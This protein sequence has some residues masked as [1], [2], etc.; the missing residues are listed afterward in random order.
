MKYRDGTGSPGQLPRTALI[1]ASCYNRV[2]LALRLHGP[3]LN[4]RLPGGRG[5]RMRLAGQEWHC[6]DERLG[7]EV[8]LVWRGFRRTG[9][10]NHPVRCLLQ[11]RHSYARVIEYTV[12]AD[13]ER[14]LASMLSVPMTMPARVLPHPA[15]SR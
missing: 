3:E 8:L 1:E 7:G 12:L 9:G 13:L 4:L 14:A 10:L 11:R 6:L 2:R 15:L 5:F